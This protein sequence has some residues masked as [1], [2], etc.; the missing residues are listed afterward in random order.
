MAIID[1]IF[2]SYQLQSFLRLVDNDFSG[3]EIELLLIHTRNT[4]ELLN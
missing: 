3:D 2:L 1:Y 4:L